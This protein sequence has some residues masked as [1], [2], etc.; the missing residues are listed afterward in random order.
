[1]GRSKRRQEGGVGLLAATWA[2][3]VSLKPTPH[4]IATF[5][6]GAEV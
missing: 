2:V 4:I 1:M 5:C 3:D 6:R